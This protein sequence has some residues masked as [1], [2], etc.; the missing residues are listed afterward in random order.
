MARIRNPPSRASMW[1]DGFFR[2]SHKLPR[3]PNVSV[4]GF[5]VSKNSTIK[6]HMLCACANCMFILVCTTWE[7]NKYIED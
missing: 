2:K 1:R 3:Q 6:T 5:Y 7:V 4:E